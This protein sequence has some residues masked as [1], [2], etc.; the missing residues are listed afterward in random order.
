MPPSVLGRPRRRLGVLA[1]NNPALN[2]TDLPSRADLAKMRLP[3]PLDPPDC[4]L[5]GSAM[6]NALK[7]TLLVVLLATSSL[8]A[9]LGAGITF[10]VNGE[11]KTYPVG[12]RVDWFKIGDGVP[13]IAGWSSWGNILAEAYLASGD[14]KYAQG[15][16]TY[17]RAFYRDCRPPAAKTT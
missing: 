17:A 9:W 4:I 12:E 5:G 6:L 3:M 14:E 16:L 15:L 2:S 1:W 7:P 8:V 13:D 10:N 11:L